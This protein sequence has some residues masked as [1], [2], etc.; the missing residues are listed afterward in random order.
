MPDCEEYGVNGF[1]GNEKSINRLLAIIYNTFKVLLVCAFLL[2]I[3]HALSPIFDYSGWNILACVFSCMLSVVLLVIFYLIAKQI[4]E[5]KDNDPE[6]NEL[7]FNFGISSICLIILLIL[8]ITDPVLAIDTALVV[9]ILLAGGCFVAMQG[10]LFTD[11]F[12]YSVS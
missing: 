1:N 2:S 6:G 10:M 5:D 8:N 7:L 11:S 9:K 3:V 4:W 12:K